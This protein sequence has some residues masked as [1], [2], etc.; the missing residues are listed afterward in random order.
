MNESYESMIERY[1]DGEMPAEERAAF[2]KRA[3][4]EP[5]LASDVKIQRELDASLR[6]LLAMPDASPAREL[7]AS[8][9]NATTPVAR[10]ETASAELVRA[11]VAGRI[12]PATS[13][14][15]RWVAAAAIVA[16][17]AGTAW[18]AW[19][20]LRPPDITI[21]IHPPI[22]PADYYHAKVNSGFKPAWKCENDQQ[23]AG[24]FIGQ[25]GTPVLLKALPAGVAAGGLDYCTTFTP[26]TVGLL[27]SVND[28]KV[29]VLIDK[30]AKDKPVSVPAESGLHLF[31]R[32]FDG[33]VAYEVT[34]LNEPRILDFLYVPERVPP[35]M[36]PVQ[37]GEDSNPS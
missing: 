26:S 34:P 29:V 27:G 13:S 12:R 37:P 30:L 6:R 36:P 16:I 35:A 15:T 5:A 4:R 18:F 2:E 20:L 10:R 24:S 3:Q 31:R 1:L 7:I 9:V 32:E 11:G 28:Q 14:W 21:V 19:D 8:V 22:S 25:L 23:F 17:V 33:L